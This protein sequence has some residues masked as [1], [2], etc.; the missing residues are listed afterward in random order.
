[1]SARTVS[2]FCEN[3]EKK[4][5][6]PETDTPRCPQCFWTS[7]VHPVDQIVQPKTFSASPG[8]RQTPAS[9]RFPFRPVLI[10][11]AVIAALALLIG[12]GGK[13]AALV[14]KSKSSISITGAKSVLVPKVETSQQAPAASKNLLQLLSDE[15]KR[16]LLQPVTLSV[17]GSGQLGDDEMQILNQRADVDFKPGQSAQFDFWTQD[18]FA[19]FL[20]TQQQKRK[21]YFSGG[22]VRLLEK[23]FEEHYVK[24]AAAAQAGNYGE[25]R[26]ELLYALHFPIYANDV[27]KHRAVALVMMKD[28]IDDVLMKVRSLNALVLAHELNESMHKLQTDYESLFD[29][30]ESKDW[31]RAFQYAGT[32]EEEAGSVD[33]KS[34]QLQTQYPEIVSEIDPDIRRGLDRQDEFLTPISTGLKSLLADLKIKKTV[35]K[36]NTAQAVQAAKVQYD[37]AM[38]AI[39][40]EKFQEALE[41]FGTVQFPHELAQDARQKESI[42]QKILSPDFA[43]AE[44]KNA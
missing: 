15:D 42:L 17:P 28:Y 19:A 40:S 9:F 35:F 43:G 41:A 11:A 22:Y 34:R 26:N 31:D 18:T 44:K 16:T 20:K 39:Q 36:Q 38:Q 24:A 21:I 6:A 23:L 30:I 5:E 29:L 32:L 13:L 12:F 8:P 10:G 3:C 27:K 4:F 14:K 2:Y 1:M 37:A 7:S 33:Q 25:A